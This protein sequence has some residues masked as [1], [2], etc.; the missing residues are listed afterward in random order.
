MGSGIS[1]NYN[2]INPT[3]TARFW[4]VHSAIKKS[5]GEEVS[6]WLLDTKEIKQSTKTKNGYQKYVDSCIESVNKLRR[7]RHP[8]VLQIYEVSDN[9]KQFG[10]SSERVEGTLESDKTLNADDITY[11]ADQLSQTLSFLHEAA[12]TLHLGIS[13]DAICITKAIKVKLCALNYSTHFE[14]E[15]ITTPSYGEY[16]EGDP[17]Q[18]EICHTAPEYLEKK[19]LLP[20]ADIFSYGTALFAAYNQKGPVYMATTTEEVVVTVSA[21]AFKTPTN[22]NDPMHDML[23]KCLSYNPEERPTLADIAKSPA[24][25]Q[26]SI[27][28]LRF[29]DLLATKELEDRMHFFQ[30]I[31]K[32]LSLFSDRLLYYNILPTFVNEVKTNDIYG[33][34]LIPVIFHIGEKLSSEDFMKNI[35]DP[36]SN[37]LKKC[38]PPDLAIAILN[39]A[40]IIIQKV[41]EDKQFELIYPIF[42]N[43]LQSPSHELRIEAIKNIPVVISAMT[44]N[45]IIT[46]LLPTLLDFVSSFDDIEI[47]CSVIQCIGKCSTKVNGDQFSL[48]I[49]PKLMICWVRLSNPLI[50]DSIIDVIENIDSSITSKMKF[51]IPMATAIMATQNLPKETITKLGDLIKSIIQELRAE[52]KLEER[53]ATWRPAEKSGKDEVQ[54]QAPVKVAQIDPE[55]IEVS[56]RRSSV[57][58]SSI[59]GGPGSLTQQS[60]MPPSQQPQQQSLYQQSQPHVTSNEESF[61]NAMNSSLAADQPESSEKKRSLKSFFGFGKKKNTENIEE[62]SLA[63]GYDTS[64]VAPR[65]G[66]PGPP[67]SLGG[68][69][70]S[71]PRN[72]PPAPPLVPQQ[73]QQSLYQQAQQT[74]SLYAQPQQPQQSLYQQVQKTQSLYAQQPQS[75]AQQQSLYSQQLQSQ[76]QQQSL[77]SQQPQSQPQQQSLYSQQLQAQPQQQMPITAS[78]NYASTGS[79]P[80]ANQ[81]QPPQTQ[82]APS[83]FAGMNQ[84]PPPKKSTPNQSLF[85]GLNMRNKK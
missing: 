69:I 19:P 7:L 33:P 79:L 85:S 18:P 35:I 45:S 36:L 37:T 68:P 1:D 48:I 74:Q 66:P 24:F 23:I 76:P 3:F 81:Q 77:Y 50:A 41:P 12:K 71:A 49:M 52:R 82:Q 65:T 20:S 64:S 56:R 51:V 31:I 39:V 72:G 10:F 22:M 54:I 2:N 75:Q 57:D 14:N 44:E 4:K 53:A 27:R 67:S 29:L 15:P 62:Q 73:Q 25:F 78:Q 30:N 13:P 40:E 34:V 59:P 42:I 83:M 16:I 61:G 9:P 32:S 5:T 11:V 21:G 26:L 70:G 6:L 55:K 84:G 38:S 47:V 63:Q 43:S 80:T 17:L 46:S 58:P 8:N 28:S 60:P